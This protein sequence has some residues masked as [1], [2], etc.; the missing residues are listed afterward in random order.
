MTMPVLADIKKAF[1]AARILGNG[2]DRVALSE[3]ELFCVLSQCCRDLAVAPSLSRSTGS[4]LI[5]VPA[6]ELLLDYSGAGPKL[7]P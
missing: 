2:D 7:G 4:F 6:P 1:S 3:N 5:L